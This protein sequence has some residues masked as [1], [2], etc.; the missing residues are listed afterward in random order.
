M[1]E[2][3]VKARDCI[4]QTAECTLRSGVIALFTTPVFMCEMVPL[5]FYCFRR[6]CRKVNFTH[7]KDFL[8]FNARGV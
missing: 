1:T 6:K 2:C 7:L 5:K 8:K 3:D 4:E